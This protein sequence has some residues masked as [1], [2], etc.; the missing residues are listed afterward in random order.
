MEIT[1]EMI[2]AR[3]DAVSREIDNGRRSG[4]CSD[5]LH[6]RVLVA[7]LDSTRAKMLAGAV[8]AE[9]LMTTDPVLFAKAY[10]MGMADGITL[11][12]SQTL[13]KL[14]Q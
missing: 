8:C 4:S 1:A 11:A 6:C 5:C 12:E 7:V 3:L 2:N 13:E 10:A 9:F 14:T